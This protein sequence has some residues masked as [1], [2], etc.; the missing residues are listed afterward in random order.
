MHT[1]AMRNPGGPALLGASFGKDNATVPETDSSSA[2][3]TGAES[4]TKA[5]EKIH[6]QF[7]GRHVTILCNPRPQHLPNNRRLGYDKTKK[8]RG[9]GAAS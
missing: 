5:D 7:R 9:N 2:R 8:D 3:S 1:W 6:L 4:K